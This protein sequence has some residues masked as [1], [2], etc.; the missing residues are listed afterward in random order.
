M[1]GDGSLAGLA[2]GAVL[3]LE[4]DHQRVDPRADA[5]QRHLVAGGRARPCSTAMAIVIGKATEP[6]LPRNSSVVKS[7]AGSSPSAVEHPLAMARADLMAK[8]PIDLVAVP[9]DF[10][11]KGGKRFGAGG[12]AGLEQPLGVG[13]HQGT[14][15]IGHGF[16]LPAAAELVELGVRPGGRGQDSVLGAAQ[17]PID[18]QHGAT[19]RADGQ[20]GHGQLDVVARQRQIAVQPIDRRFDQLPAALAADDQA[21]ADLPQLDHVGH[22]QHSV[23][24]AQAGVRE[25]EDLALRR[26]P[27][28]VM[29]A[30]GGGRFEM[31]AADRGVDQRP[32]VAPIDARAASSSFAA[33]DALRLG[34]VPTGQNRRSRMP[35]ISSSRP[36]GSR[37]RS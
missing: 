7:R 37:S 28:P 10:G 36:A 9:A 2:P 15:A 18:Q 26:Q 12:D 16:V 8:R 4:A 32:D 34:S 13:P 17:P 27:Q 24:D 1:A 25:V 21:G 35:V 3:P 33:F 22:G 29:H 19:G 5:Q 23:E 11:Q 6:V 30:A 20:T 31:I 14:H